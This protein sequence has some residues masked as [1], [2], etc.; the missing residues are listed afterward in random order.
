MDY[1]LNLFVISSILFQN[2]VKLYLYQL[3][4]SLYYILKVLL[5]TFLNYQPIQLIL[6]FKVFKNQKLKNISL[7]KNSTIKILVVDLI[8]DGCTCSI[9]DYQRHVC[10]VAIKESCWFN[11]SSFI[12]SECVSR[13]Y[14]LNLNFLFNFILAQKTYVAKRDFEV[15]II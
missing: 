10:L 14:N 6:Y 5:S 1:K 9:I 12:I 4:Y 8:I 2:L 15:R 11:L 7:Q 13:F 3:Q